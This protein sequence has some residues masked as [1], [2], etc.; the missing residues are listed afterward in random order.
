[1]PNYNS[2]LQ[3]NNADLQTVLQT[4]QTKVAG[5]GSSGAT[6]SEGSFSFTVEEDFE[7]MVNQYSLSTTGLNASER[8]IIL[9]LA[10]NDTSTDQEVVACVYRKSLSDNWFT[11]KTNNYVLSITYDATP[12]T[13]NA[14]TLFGTPKYGDTVTS[15]SY[16]AI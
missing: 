16:F 6:F 10:T 8:C 12:E 9:I 15:F 4:L 7:P 13:D 11:V 5:G 14:L 3:S 1:M 2:T